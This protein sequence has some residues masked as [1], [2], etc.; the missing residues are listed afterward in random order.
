MTWKKLYNVKREKQ[1]I[2][3]YVVMLYNPDYVNN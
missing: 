2:E 1:D 3:L